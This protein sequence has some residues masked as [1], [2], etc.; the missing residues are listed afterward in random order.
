MGKDTV[1][2]SFKM[3]VDAVVME[4]GGAAL[5]GVVTKPLPKGVEIV[6]NG[7][8]PH[9]LDV[10]LSGAYAVAPQMFDFVT[11]LVGNFG[12]MVDDD[13]E[14]DGGDAVQY[15]SA[16]VQDARKVLD[17]TEA[18]KPS[19][20]YDAV[21]YTLDR[22][23]ENP[24]LRHYLLGTQMFELLCAAEAEHL[25]S[26]VP[27]VRKARSADLQPLHRWRRPDVAVF[28]KRLEEADLST[29]NHT[30]DVRPKPL[31]VGGGPFEPLS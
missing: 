14:I 25:G 17:G 5:C 3:T 16:L 27:E 18:K 22:M 13:S 8:L 1:V 20:L 29:D 24:D 30:H 19:Q 11:D 4:D 12:P 7:T 21:K 26:K 9:P 10:K 31:R 28:R 6:G 2:S 15:I 23:Q